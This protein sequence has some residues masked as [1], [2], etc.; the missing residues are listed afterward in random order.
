MPIGKMTYFKFLVLIS[1]HPD[2]TDYTISGKEF[3]QA[4]LQSGFLITET[5]LDVDNKSHWNN[6]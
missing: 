2:S 6:K 4:S 3:L 5:F 1:S